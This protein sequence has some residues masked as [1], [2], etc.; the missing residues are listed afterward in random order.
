M[1]IIIVN[2][3]VLLMVNATFIKLG[4]IEAVKLLAKASSLQKKTTKEKII[5]LINIE[6]YANYKM[7]AAKPKGKQLTQL[8]SY[9]F[10]AFL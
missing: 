6:S 2:L 10:D 5:S 3:F 1:P 7:K 9:H 4:G 8:S